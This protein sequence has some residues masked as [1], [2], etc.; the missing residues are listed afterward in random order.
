[1][2]SKTVIVA[3]AVGLHARPA[4]LISQAA[5]AFDD[6]IELS[7]EGGDAVDAASTLMIMTLGASK[8]TV[9]TVTS[10]NADAVELI[11]G[12]IETD[13]DA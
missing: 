6:D 7:V 4:T 10:D 12:M 1:M 2:P 8:G 11:A 13:L 5:A 9:V 3:S